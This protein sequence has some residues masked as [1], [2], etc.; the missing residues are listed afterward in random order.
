MIGF[1]GARETAIA[2]EWLPR[3]FL[4]HLAHYLAPACVTIAFLLL[5]GRPSSLIW[6]RLSALS[7]GVYL[8]HPIVLD[9]LEVAERGWTLRPAITVTFNFVAVTLLSF[10]AVLLASHVPILRNLFSVQET[11][12]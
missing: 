8:F 9:L 12:R 10:Q 7:F 4:G 1:E 11:L 6:T 2:G 3:D 5:V